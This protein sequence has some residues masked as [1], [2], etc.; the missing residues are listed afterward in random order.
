MEREKLGVEDSEKDVEIVVN[1]IE[2]DFLPDAITL[3]V[4]KFE[5]G[6]DVLTKQLREDVVS[7]KMSGVFS[8]L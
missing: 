1:T 7:S 8:E 6:Q 5:L 2:Q 4:L 3:D